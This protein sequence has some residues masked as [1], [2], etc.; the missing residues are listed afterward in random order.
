MAEKGTKILPESDIIIASQISVRPYGSSVSFFTPSCYSQVFSHN[1]HLPPETR[2]EPTAC[3]TK[4]LAVR[5]LSSVIK[6]LVMLSATVVR[7]GVNCARLFWHVYYFFI[8]ITFI[9][10]SFFLILVVLFFTKV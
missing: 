2:R 3:R 5:F 8:G 7:I 10:K 9:H 4:D 1:L 6:S